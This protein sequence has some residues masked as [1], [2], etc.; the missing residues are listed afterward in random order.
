MP[1]FSSFSRA[2]GLTLGAC[3]LLT[4]CTSQ[5]LWSQQKRYAPQWEYSPRQ[6]NQYSFAWQAQGDAALWP[7]QTFSTGQ[8]VWLEYDSSRIPTF[9][10]VDPKTQ[11]LT[12]L[13]PF[14]NPPY[15]VLKGDHHWLQLRSQEGQAELFHLP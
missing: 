14:F 9:F 11:Q 10:A 4:A 3:L 5:P 15:V 12:L 8:E 2:T 13:K 1:R 7:R 6:V